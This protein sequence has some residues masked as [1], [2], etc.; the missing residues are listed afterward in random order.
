MRK[1]NYYFSL[2]SL[3]KLDISHCYNINHSICD[4]LRDNSNLELLKA[5]GLSNAIDDDNFHLLGEIET[6]IHLD[7]SQCTYISDTSLEKFAQN[8]KANSMK[9]LNLSSIFKLS[10][11]G[12]NAIISSQQLSLNSLDIST[13]P[14]VNYI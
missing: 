5:S 14:Q 11:K 4:I 10:S 13:L 3:A 1:S 12:L 8:K 7:V 9:S 6:L 2:P